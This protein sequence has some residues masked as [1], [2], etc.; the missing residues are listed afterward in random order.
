MANICFKTVSCYPTNTHAKSHCDATSIHCF[1]CS[2][3]CSSFS[4]SVLWLVLS[5]ATIHQFVHLYLLFWSS[6]GGRLKPVRYRISFQIISRR[7]IIF[8]LVKLGKRGR[9]GDGE[10][11]WLIDGVFT[12]LFLSLM[13]SRVRHWFT[14]GY[15]RPKSLCNDEYQSIFPFVHATTSIWRRRGGNKRR[16]HYLQYT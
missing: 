9:R 16:W 7:F 1:V 8:G 13:F 12:C 10:C 5:I 14:E 4:S 2:R 15:A 11:V 3:I 6:T